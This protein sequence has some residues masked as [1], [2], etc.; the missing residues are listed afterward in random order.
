MNS[1]CGSDQ[2]K[3]VQISGMDHTILWYRDVT[4]IPSTLEPICLPLA[5]DKSDVVEK[6]NLKI[7]ILQL[8]YYTYR[9]RYFQALRSYW[10]YIIF[11]FIESSLY[12]IWQQTSMAWGIL[13][14]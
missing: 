9:K 8:L 11:L 10:D 14:P 2:Q 12:S 4:F 5:D 1:G 13:V 6:G 7:V 3:K